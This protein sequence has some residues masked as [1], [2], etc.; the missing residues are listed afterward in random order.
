MAATVG[1][2]PHFGAAPIALLQ[3]GTMWQSRSWRGPLQ[4]KEMLGHFFWNNL[5]VSDSP[6]ASIL[7][8]RGWGRL[9]LPGRT[10]ILTLRAS[11][12]GL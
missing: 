1:L 5:E 4:F 11:S 2:W 12:P 8:A 7:D 3:W 10:E 6:F 9:V